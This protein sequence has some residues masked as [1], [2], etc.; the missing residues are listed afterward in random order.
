MF[1]IDDAPN[2]IIYHASILKIS[3]ASS[4]IWC[5]PAATAAQDRSNLHIYIYIYIYMY[6]CICI[7]TYLYI[8]NIYVCVY[9]YMYIYIYIQIWSCETRH[10]ELQVSN[11]VGFHGLSWCPQGGANPAPQAD[12]RQREQ[13]PFRDI[14]RAGIR[15]QTLCYRAPEVG[16]PQ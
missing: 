16:S 7:Y 2:W 11:S 12:S 10:E 15:M 4:F 3:D 14:A 6:I 5:P 8:Y 1:T 9:I 13:K